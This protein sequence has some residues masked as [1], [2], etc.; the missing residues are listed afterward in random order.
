MAE[1]ERALTKA[2]M[3]ITEGMPLQAAEGDI[4]ALRKNV[5]HLMDMEAIR[6]LKYAYF[7]CIDTANM[8]ELSTLFHEDVRVHFKGGT[9][10]WELKG[11]KEYL[12]NVGG[13]F[14]SQAVGH[15]N[16]HHPEIQVHSDTEASGIWYLADHMWI[17]DPGYYTTGTALYWDRYVKENG[18][19][20]ILETC[21]ERLYEINRQ[22][23]DVPLSAHYLARAGA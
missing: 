6:Q 21:Y 22:E 23:T 16:G 13:A 11:K 20:L 2:G 10:E 8:E 19:W 1:S 14:S 4:E 3:G 15:H 17:L 9:Y 5:Q 18:R 12:D 7:R